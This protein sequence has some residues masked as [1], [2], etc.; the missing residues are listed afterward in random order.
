MSHIR[1]MAALLTLLVASAFV[2]AMVWKPAPAPAFVGLGTQDVPRSVGGYTAPTDYEMTPEVRVA[3]ASADLVSR[4]YS[5]GAQTLDFVLIGGTDRTALHDPR[6]CLVGAGWRLE[7]DH[8]ETLPGTDVAAHACH[9][10]GQPGAPGLDIIYLYVVDGRVINEV[11]Q[12]RTAMLWSA[13]LGRKNTPVY[14]LRFTRPLDDDARQRDDDHQQ[15][16]RFASAMWTDIA[17][18]APAKDTAMRTST[19]HARTTVANVLFDN[20]GMEEAVTR[21]I[22]MTQKTDRPRYV[23]TGNL[24]HLVLL[25]KD[26]AFR[27][28]YDEADLVLADGAPV[29]WLSRLPGGQPLQERVTGE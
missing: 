1:R 17:P 2:T 22:R 20:V 29:V 16:E 18:R 10:V 28:I 8:T 26:A 14:F 15:M 13:L 24:D 25:Q 11:T 7:D 3:L 5:R 19:T 4:T 27:A 12:I 9:A 21:I 23:C 6:S